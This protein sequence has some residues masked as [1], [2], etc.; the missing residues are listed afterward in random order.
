MDNFRA[1]FSESNLDI[2]WGL[3]ILNAGHTNIAPNMQYPI[4]NHP[5]NYKLNFKE[6]R[7]LNELQVVYIA[8][9]SGVFESITAGVINV[10]S[11]SVFFVFPGEWHRYSPNKE[12]GWEEY[13][14]GLSGT[15]MEHIVSNDFIQRKH[16]VLK[17]NSSSDILN[18]FLNI[19]E[20][21]R[22][23]VIGFQQ[24]ASGASL[25]LIG[26]IY[27]LALQK[28]FNY[29]KYN[30]IIFDA[31]KIYSER[32]NTPIA[33][34]GVAEELNIGYSLFRK[35]FKSHTGFSPNQYLIEL[36]INKAK[37]LL[38]TTNMSIEEVGGE[39]GFNTLYY[40]SKLFKEKTGQTPS[41]WRKL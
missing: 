18:Q 24:V 1:Y 5:D 3:S 8:N 2:K 36:R 19:F 6:G 30:S 16:P 29:N 32:I 12:T 37:D 35:V 10:T 41:D 38:R 22:E 34:R 26:K 13:W 25:M 21:L 40:F 39:V 11:G 33:P 23:E 17:L 15:F 20:I 27:S 9:G 31:K 4:S 28:D 7:V 14:I